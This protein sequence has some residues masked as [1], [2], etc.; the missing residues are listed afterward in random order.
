VINTVYRYQVGGSLPIDS[1]TY[2]NRQADQDLY[3]ALKAG[4]L[5]YVFN[6]RQ[7]GKSSLA[8]QTMQRL[9]AEGIACTAIDITEIGS[10]RVTPEQW[11]A[12][13]IRTLVNSF[14][15]SD[16]VNVSRWWRDRGR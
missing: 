12:G 13:L 3:N 1:P 8:V 14:N 6:S 4:E 9:E 15:L 10:Q 16:H 11:Y 2:V 5:C 7:M